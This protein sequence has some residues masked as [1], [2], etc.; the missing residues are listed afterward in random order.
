MGVKTV[1]AA[2]LFAPERGRRADGGKLYSLA[3]AYAPADL[4]TYPSDIE[5]FGN[6]FLEAIYY[7]RPLVMCAYDVYKIDIRPK[8]FRVIEFDEYITQE[9]VRRARDSAG[10]GAL[11]EEMAAHNYA[12]AREHYSFTVLERLLVGLLERCL[13]E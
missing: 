13:G 4:V 9:T 3:D 6:A 11:A 10:P 12:V 5:G 8:G 2:E 1:F 7:G